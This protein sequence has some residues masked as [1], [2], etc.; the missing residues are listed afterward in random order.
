MFAGCPAAEKFSMVHA[1][2]SNV[3]RHGL[4]RVVWKDLE[5]NINTSES[6]YTLLLDEATT[7]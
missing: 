2:A 7:K 6:L 5:K 1:K 4:E 3:V